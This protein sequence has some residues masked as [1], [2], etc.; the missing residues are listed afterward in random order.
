MNVTTTAGETKTYTPSD[1]NAA[2]MYGQ[3]FLFDTTKYTSSAVT[4][5]VKPYAVSLDGSTT[6]Y[7]DEITLS[8]DVC[9]ANGTHLFKEGQ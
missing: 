8:E 6:Y 5:Y 9:A 1:L 2:Y 3:Q 4:L 7:G